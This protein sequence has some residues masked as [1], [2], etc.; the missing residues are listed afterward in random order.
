MVA[1][2]YHERYIIR[3]VICSRLTT[4]KDV[5]YSW[6]QIKEE[7]DIMS[8]EENTKPEF[9]A[10]NYIQRTMLNEKSQ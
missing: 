5:D 6:N 4:K 8:S 3:F 7:A 10:I 2:R 9:T 1:W